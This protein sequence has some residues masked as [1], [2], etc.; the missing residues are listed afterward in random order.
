MK[1]VLE[2][3]FPVS[4]GYLVIW[5]TLKRTFSNEDSFRTQFSSFKWI[6]S[7]MVHFEEDIQQ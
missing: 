5:Y 6:F 1:T 3:S 2:H 7:D 4:S